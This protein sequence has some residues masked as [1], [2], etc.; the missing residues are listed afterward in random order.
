M[1]SPHTRAGSAHRQGGSEAGGRT[2]DAKLHPAKH[3]V[4]SMLSV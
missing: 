2:D 1:I 4:P 3:D